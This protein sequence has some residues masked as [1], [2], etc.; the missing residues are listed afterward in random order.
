M[1]T[2]AAPTREQALADLV[3][4]LGAGGSAAHEIGLDDDL[5]DHG[6]DSVRLMALLERWRAA[7][8][9]VEFAQVAVEPTLRGCLRALGVAT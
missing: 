7:G 9:S 1:T 2:T 3:D 4:V 6:L 5:I 8:W